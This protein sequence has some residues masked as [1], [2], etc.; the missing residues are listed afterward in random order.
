MAKVKYNFY[1]I[2]CEICGDKSNIS[3]MEGEASMQFAVDSMTR[4]INEVILH[5]HSNHKFIINKLIIGTNNL[6][7]IK[8][9]SRVEDDKKN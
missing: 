8:K 6:K 1:R 3:S 5:N 4:A 7:E 2:N 9:A